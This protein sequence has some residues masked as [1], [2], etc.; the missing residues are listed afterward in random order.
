M[1]EGAAG[2]CPVGRQRDF[3]EPAVLLCGAMSRSN[4]RSGTVRFGPAG[5]DYPD[6]KGKVYPVPKPK[7]FDPLR[8]LAEYFDTVERLLKR[9]A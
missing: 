2:W 9:S 7:G 5:W 3:D 1:S 8:Y 4:A 6:W